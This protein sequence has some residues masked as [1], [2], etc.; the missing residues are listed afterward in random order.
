MANRNAFDGINES[1]ACTLSK[2]LYT[3]I[4]MANINTDDEEKIKSGMRICGISNP[5]GFQLATK[6]EIKNSLRKKLT[7]HPYASLISSIHDIESTELRHNYEILCGYIIAAALW[8]EPS[9]SENKSYHARIRRGLAE[10]RLISQDGR[11]EILQS[12]GR[13]YKSFDDLYAILLKLT[14]NSANKFLVGILNLVAT[15]IDAIRDPS[16]EGRQVETKI[17]ETLESRVLAADE[18]DG[19]S[20]ISQN[21]YEAD[22]RTKSDVIENHCV[23]QIIRISSKKGTKIPRGNALFQSKAIANAYQKKLMAFPSDKDALTDYEIANIIDKCKSE[24]KSK[25]RYYDEAFFTLASLMTGR[26]IS[27]LQQIKVLITEPSELQTHICSSHPVSLMI[28]C[29]NATDASKVVGHEAM[30]PVHNRYY[31]LVLPQYFKHLFSSDFSQKARRELSIANFFKNQILSG[32]RKLTEKKIAGALRRNLTEENVDSAIIGIIIGE[33]INAK[34][35]IHYTN[36]TNK[37]LIDNYNLGLKKYGTFAEIPE[38][39]AQENTN[40]GSIRSIDTKATR[41]FYK[42]APKYLRKLRK[43]EIIDFINFHNRYAS[44]VVLNLFFLTAHRPVIAPFDTMD[45]YDPETAYIHINDKQ[46]RKSASGRQVPLSNTAKRQIDEWIN[47]VNFVRKRICGFP[48]YLC[49]VGHLNYN[50]NEEKL[51]KTIIDSE[52]GCLFFRIEVDRKERLIESSPLSVTSIEDQLSDI[53]KPGLRGPRHALR[54]FAIKEGLSG[55]IIDSLL[56]HSIIGAEPFAS[57][58][59]M[60]MKYHQELRKF[61]NKY[62]SDIGA[63]S[64]KGFS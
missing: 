51:S 2:N 53:W 58:S 41:A 47:H 5:S 45:S 55:E 12:I 21:S 50:Y 22:K 36:L 56:G 49:G 4:E 64:F 33:T 60:S 31:R 28:A 52:D 3:L 23:R 13:D 15:P 40:H 16:R 7:S 32:G 19:F 29:Q 37:C 54:S 39:F 44:L 43:T 18:P 14:N 26:T 38:C 34:T 63:V 30:T 42:L 25:G 20:L 59:G 8:T 9:A 17:Y 57:H 61:L 46:I 24:L 1:V 11:R 62:S 6:R 27:E 10:T 48:P 35:S